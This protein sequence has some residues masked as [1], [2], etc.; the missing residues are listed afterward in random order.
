MRT[1]AAN[2]CCGHTFYVV[3]PNGSPP[4]AQH[5]ESVCSKVRHHMWL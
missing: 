2:K 4:D 5:L 1:Y 3:G